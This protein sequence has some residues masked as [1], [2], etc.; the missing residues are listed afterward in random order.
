MSLLNPDVPPFPLPDIRK[1]PVTSRA[2]EIK[3]KE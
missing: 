1:K 3:I 2:I